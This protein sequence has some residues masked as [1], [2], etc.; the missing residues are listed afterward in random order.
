MKNYTIQSF[1]IYE[2]KIRTERGVMSAVLFYNAEDKIPYEIHAKFRMNGK[3]YIYSR[4][5]RCEER[6]DWLL[7][8]KMNRELFSQIRDDWENR[9]REFMQKF[10]HPVHVIA[11]RG[12]LR[13]IVNGAA[14]LIPNGVGD[15]DYT[16]IT[17]KLDVW[18][19]MNL[20]K[21]GFYEVAT[22]ED[23]QITIESNDCGT[24]MPV[25]VTSGTVILYRDRHGNFAAIKLEEMGDE[26]NHR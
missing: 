21:F 8:V 10:D 20:P 2:A 7:D 24:G 23:G 18:E 14:V 22:F 25:F 5:F 26:K 6:N 12:A 13:I 16:V 4:G 9:C 11:D 1:G 15:G 19:I 17:G 3:C